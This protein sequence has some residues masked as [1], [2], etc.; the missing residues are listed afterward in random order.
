[1]N[2][3]LRPDRCPTPECLGPEQHQPV[4]EE[5]DRGGL[6]RGKQGSQ[7]VLEQQA[8]QP[9][10]NRPHDQEPSELRVGVLRR[11]VAV[12]KRAAEA[13]QDPNPVLEE[14]EEKDNGRRAVGRY[15]EAQEVVVVLVD[16]PTEDAREHDAVPEARDRE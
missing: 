5:E 7:R 8:E 10:G 11:D 12:A 3:G 15:Q 14:E 6:G 2:A 16:V 1:M 4:D 9:R 13:L